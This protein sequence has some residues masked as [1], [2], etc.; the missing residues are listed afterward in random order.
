MGLGRICG[1]GV[2]LL[3]KE[4][5]FFCMWRPKKNILIPVESITDINNPKSHIH[6]SILRPLLKI[7]FKNEKGESNSVTWFVQQLI[8][9][10]EILENLV[11]AEN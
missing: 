3:T 7:T 6:K 1:N 11:L 5:L 2:L 10:N 4:V 8:Q 9:W